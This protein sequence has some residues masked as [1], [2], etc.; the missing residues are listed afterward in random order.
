M[1][2]KLKFE[3][4]VLLLSTILHEK[5]EALAS[6]FRQNSL[7]ESCRALSLENSGTN[8]TFIAIIEREL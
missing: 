1:Y 2:R 4:N 7:Y 8:L 5:L 3:L 6:I